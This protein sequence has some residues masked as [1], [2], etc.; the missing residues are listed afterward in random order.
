MSDRVE[1]SEI[2]EHL[3][4][5]RIISSVKVVSVDDS[6]QRSICRLRCNLLPSR[7]KL[8]IRL[9]QTEIEIIY[10]YQLFHKRPILRWNNAPHFP[11]IATFP[12]HCH[13]QKGEIGKSNLIGYVLADI[14]LVLKEIKKFLIR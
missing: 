8:D 4:N 9:I 1:L 5:K 10:S 6:I 14:D 2:I 13:N 7:F 12:H 3:K 11:D